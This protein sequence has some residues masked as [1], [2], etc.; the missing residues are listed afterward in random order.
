MF[1]LHTATAAAARDRRAKN[2]KKN[3]GGE[4]AGEVGA[5][6]G[7]GGWRSGEVG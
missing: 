3:T 5:M 6:I 2:K 4:G 1:I 7:V